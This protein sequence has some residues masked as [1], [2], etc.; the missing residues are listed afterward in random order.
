MRSNAINRKKE[1]EVISLG[2]VEEAGKEA[3]PG[4]Y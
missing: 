3:L 4:K 1:I 2:R